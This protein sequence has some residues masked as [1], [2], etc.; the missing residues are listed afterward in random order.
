MSKRDYYEVLG[1]SKSS[2]KKEIK[3]AYKKL[4][5]KYHPDKNP[6]DARAE[7]SFKEV[8]EAYEILTNVE[9]RQ[10]YDRFGHAAFDNSGSGQR[11]QHSAQ[12]GFEDMFGSGFRQQNQGFGGGGFGGFEDIFS[13]ARGG[14]RARPRKGQ[15]LEFNL[16]VDFV[17]AVKG[18]D[19]IVELPMNGQQKKINVK[20]P[21]GIKDGEKI[22]FSGKGGLS[23]NGGPAGDLL[24]VIKTRPH[25]VLKRE[26]NNLI[27]TSHIDMVTAAL[28][29]EV[30]VNVFDNK[31]KLKMPAGTQSGRK[32]K[33][34][35]RGVTDRKGVTGDLLVSIHVNTPTQLTDQ[36]KELLEQFKA[37]L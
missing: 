32:F 37:T 26:E 35:G 21:A 19:K 14:G 2:S 10:E 6:D 3:K 5:M 36:Q 4:A 17:D 16:T 24:I 1:V 33:I 34:S 27:C 7:E 18:T 23:A 20:I 29:G 28:G 22:R 11:Q 31:F 25:P 9:K 12:G 15:D 30:E 13:Q 8:K